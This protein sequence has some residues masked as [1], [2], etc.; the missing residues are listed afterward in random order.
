MNNILLLKIIILSNMFLT[1]LWKIKLYFNKNYKSSHNAHGQEI[2]K[3]GAKASF[4][5]EVTS[6][7]AYKDGNGRK[8]FDEK[9]A[10]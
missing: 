1:I 4:L 3:K 8:K 5:N 6:P 7:L 2:I 10:L 9:G